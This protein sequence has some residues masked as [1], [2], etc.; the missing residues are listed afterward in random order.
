MSGYA[1]NYAVPNSERSYEILLRSEGNILGFFRTK[2][3][4]TLGDIP[5]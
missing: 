5:G 3:G 4:L 2:S 1:D